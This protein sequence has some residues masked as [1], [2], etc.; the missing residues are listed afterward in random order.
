[1]ATLIHFIGLVV[2]L[3]IWYFAPENF[4][5]AVAIA[6]P[7]TAY[8]LYLFIGC[9]CNDIHEYLRNIQPGE[10]FEM[11]Y[12]RV[13][14]LIGSLDFSCECYHY[15]T[16]YHVRHHTHNGETRIE[17]YTTQV[18]VVTHTAAESVTPAY[19]TDQSGQVDRI[20]FDKD[21]IFIHFIVNYRF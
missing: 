12:D 4:T 8:V 5:Q 21:I 15:E 19:T 10:S 14:G 7:I 1:M 17:T 16:R 20:Q 11:E 18:K 13:Q 9:I 3:L 2:S 6:I